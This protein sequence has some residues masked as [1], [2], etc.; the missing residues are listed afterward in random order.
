MLLNMNLRVC[1]RSVHVQVSPCVQLQGWPS[2]TNLL[3]ALVHSFDHKWCICHCVPYRHCKVR[4]A[5]AH[6]SEQLH[7]YSVY[8]L[9]QVGT[10]TSVLTQEARRAAEAAA[11]ALVQAAGGIC[12]GKPRRL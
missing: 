9:A 2:A 10:S 5:L 12:F 8:V 7:K 6:L 3:V 4:V 11:S 1:H